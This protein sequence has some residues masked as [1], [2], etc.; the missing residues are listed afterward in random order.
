MSFIRK[1]ALIAFTAMASAVAFTAPMSAE[2]P[3]SNFAIQTVQGPVA[4]GEFQKKKYR[5]KGAWAIEARADGDYIV[6]SEDFKTKS[7]PDLKI[8]L[9]PKTVSDVTGT[10][11]VDGSVLVSVLNTNKGAQE[12]RIPDGVNLADFQSVLIH[13]E[14]FSVLWG[15][16]DL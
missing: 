14:A 8:F 16:G 1:S 6:L 13:C 10:T 4:S 15:G 9:S 7:G 5:I 3:T 11:A 2:T 12:Y